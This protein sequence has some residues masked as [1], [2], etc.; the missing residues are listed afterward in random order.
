M[1]EISS[2][3]IPLSPD[4]R[5]GSPTDIHVPSPITVDV[6]S[7]VQNFTSALE[8][9]FDAKTPDQ[10]ASAES[11]LSNIASGSSA[12]VINLQPVRPL[13]SDSSGTSDLASLPTPIST[14]IVNESQSLIKRSFELPLPPSITSPNADDRPLNPDQRPPNVHMP[15]SPNFA[16]ELL[17]AIHAG[18][19]NATSAE[20]IKQ[21]LVSGSDGDNVVSHNG[22]PNAPGSAPSAVTQTASSSHLMT[23]PV[24]PSVQSSKAVEPL[25][26]PKALA[27]APPPQKDPR[28]PVVRPAITASP[29]Y[30]ATQLHPIS[31]PQSH[32]N[33][34]RPAGLQQAPGSKQHHSPDNYSQL[35][36][37]YSPSGAAMAALPPH[38]SPQSSSQRTGQ[39]Q[40]F[41]QPIPAPQTQSQ[42]ATL[43]RV[44]DLLEGLPDGVVHALFALMTSQERT[45]I[46]APNQA[47][48]APAQVSIVARHIVK[49]IGKIESE[50]QTHL[51]RRSQGQPH[52]DVDQMTRDLAETRAWLSMK[53]RPTA[54]LSPSSSSMPPAQRLDQQPQ[55]KKANGK[56][57]ILPAIQRQG[58]PGS[59]GSQAPPPPTV[60]ASFNSP[61]S[62]DLNAS[63]ASWCAALDQ[64]SSHMQAAW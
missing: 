64:V 61:S 18:K 36:N 16:R 41:Q 2:R 62:F 29:K 37:L 38:I 51:S 40:S 55:P 22:S 8:T 15:R 52:S 44:K 20:S 45:Q 27:L 3:P 6:D 58:S 21:G 48:I 23:T 49:V 63:E 60:L 35:Q 59:S 43:K 24:L 14:P 33:P 12:S 1:T 54:S 46:Y 42:Q 30:A 5:P 28:F 9:E 13:R 4:S 47:C 10:P 32:S 53:A 26:P 11:Q 57:I 7:T 56:A 19:L 17:N 34:M 31:S 50:L 39:R 25:I